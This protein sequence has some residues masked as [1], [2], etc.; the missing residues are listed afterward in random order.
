MS[1]SNLIPL[2]EGFEKQREGFLSGLEARFNDRPIPT[3]EQFAII[4]EFSY[5]KTLIERGYTEIT[6]KSLVVAYL[7]TSNLL[8][9]RF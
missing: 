3:E 6:L 8:I 7:Q 1:K 5:Y 2:I 9:Q 4:Q